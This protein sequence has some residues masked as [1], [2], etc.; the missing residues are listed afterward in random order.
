MYACP[1][2]LPE[3]ANQPGTGIL[4]AAGIDKLYAF[5]KAIV[6]D[7]AIAHTLA[8]GSHHTCTIIRNLL[9][10]YI[11]AP[12]TI[13]ILSVVTQANIMSI[14]TQ[15]L[16]L[17]VYLLRDT[18]MLGKTMIYKKQYIHEQLIFILHDSTWKNTII[19]KDFLQSY[20]INMN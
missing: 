7:A 10:I 4:K 3:E 2:K 13:S 9:L 14:L 20:E 18:T 11:P 6:K 16:D 1:S 19:F 15:A 17:I 12:V 5:A 8:Q